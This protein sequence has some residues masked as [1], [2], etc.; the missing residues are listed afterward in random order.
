M[1]RAF[2][3]RKAS[4]EKRWGNMSRIFPKL[5]KNIT[6]AA[7][8]GTSNPDMNP[9]LRSAIISAKAENM[10]KDLINKA[11]KRASDKDI[12]ELKELHYEAKSKYGTLFIIECASDNHTRTISNLKAI[13]TRNSAEILSTNALDFLFSRKSIFHINIDD[14]INLE[15][16][17][18]DLINDGLEELNNI[19]ILDKNKNKIDIIEIKGEFTS[20]GDLSKSLEEKKID[21][22][23]ASTEYIPTSPINLK[24]EE[25]DEILILLDK[26]DEDN[27][28]QIV[29]N[30][31][32]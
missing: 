22:I 5:G 13:L 2:E 8:N 6:L 26:L 30:N 27:D 12:S 25:L 16:F 19:S 23:K 7:K 18:L 1:G 28:V 15:E 9:K 32:I 3:Y 24:D 4:K 29:Y 17:E 11:I 21:I 10:P 31:I 20:F 14:N